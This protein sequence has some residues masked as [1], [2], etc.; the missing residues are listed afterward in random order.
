MTIDSTRIVNT[1]IADI[2]N[3]K[4]ISTVKDRIAGTVF[5]I[6]LDSY[7]TRRDTND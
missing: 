7:N 2:G 4:R 3:T 5:A 1:N 6:K